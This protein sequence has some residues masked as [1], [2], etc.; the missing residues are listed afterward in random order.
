[1]RFCFSNNS[2]AMKYI[3]LASQINHSNNPPPRKLI[4]PNKNMDIEG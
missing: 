4:L 1:M 2:K 3:G